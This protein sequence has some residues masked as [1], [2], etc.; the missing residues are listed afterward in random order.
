MYGEGNE[1]SLNHVAIR[2]V[3]T[4]LH[5]PYSS[6]VSSSIRLSACFP[7]PQPR[8]QPSS[9]PCYSLLSRLPAPLRSHLVQGTLQPLVSYEAS[10]V[11]LDRRRCRTLMTSHC[12]YCVADLALKRHHLGKVLLGGGGEW[13][14]SG[15]SDIARI[16][17][18]CRRP[19][20]NSWVGKIPWRR[21]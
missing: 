3:N 10:L 20:L 11:P 2:V 4:T 5:L 19:Q 15:G 18:Q 8:L 12:V 7:L 6:L 1:R 16:C 13:I 21:E 17:L 9:P 14:S